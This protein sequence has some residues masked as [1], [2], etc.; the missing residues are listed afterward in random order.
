M[1]N[2]SV[3]GPNRNNQRMRSYAFLVPLLFLSQTLTFTA[4]SFEIV[5]QE[6]KNL[7]LA[8]DGFYESNLPFYSLGK[9]ASSIECHQ[10]YQS[11]RYNYHQ[12]CDLVD[13]AN[14]EKIVNLHDIQFHHN[15]EGDQIQGAEVVILA[16]KEAHITSDTGN[17]PVRSLKVSADCVLK[18][19]IFE[20]IDEEPEDFSCKINDL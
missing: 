13:F 8:M 11:I 19:P 17:P 5:G 9:S 14:P 1:N 7:Y 12:T 20:P 2:Q 4:H 3:T 16:L 6:A 18:S 15:G 10:Y